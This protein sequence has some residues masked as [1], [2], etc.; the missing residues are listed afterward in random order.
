MRKYTLLIA[1]LFITTIGFGQSSSSTENQLKVDLPTI[2]PPSPSVAALM[3]FE[4]IPVSNYTGIPDISIPLFSTT[5]KHGLPFNMTLN[6]SPSSVKMEEVA[7]YTGL[8]W[9]LFAGG[10]ISRTVRDIPDE[11]YVLTNNFTS[12]KIGIY[13]NNSSTDY[14]NNNYYLFILNKINSFVFQELVRFFAL[15]QIKPHIPPL[16]QLPRNSFEF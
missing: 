14:D 1:I 15:Y 4:E 7:G 10:T 9:S 8:G 6:Y 11:A 13:H 2:I 16:L 12:K 3:K 5:G